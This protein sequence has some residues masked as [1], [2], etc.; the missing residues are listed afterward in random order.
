MPHAWVLLQVG[1]GMARV[2]GESKESDFV[3]FRCLRFSW[4]I[5]S[6]CISTSVMGIEEGLQ[7]KR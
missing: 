4:A 1:H 2:G 5:L 6:F 3:S 7:R